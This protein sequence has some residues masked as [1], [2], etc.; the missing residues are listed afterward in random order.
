MTLAPDP[1][2]VRL[3][4]VGSTNDEARR[5]AED[6]APHLTLVAARRQTAG[7]G[8]RGRSWVSEPGNLYCSAVLRPAGPPD[9][10]A[11]LGF[12]VSLAMAESIGP[13]ARCKWPNDLLVN[14][15]KAAGMLMESGPVRGGMM[16]WLIA[17]IGVNVAQAPADTEFPATSLHAEG[18][19]AATVDGL[20]EGFAGRLAAWLEVWRDAG[21]APLRA[22]WIGRAHGIGG[23][24]TLRLPR[25][26]LHGRFADLD[27]TGALV[28]D[29][30]GAS[31]HISVGDVF[32]G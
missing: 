5:L 30:G 32:F 7:R 16:D 12:A 21:F 31:R 25:E 3:D 8:R 20:L 15:R 26:T 19:G 13:E 2:I 28:L 11:E 14:G 27:E 18:L 1:R 22:A 29:S 9:R 17:G 6:G 4:A 10:A 24:V 23:P